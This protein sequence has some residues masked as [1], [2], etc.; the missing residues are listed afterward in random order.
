MRDRQEISREIAATETCNA[1][2]DNLAIHGGARFEMQECVT[3]HNPGSADANS[4][5]TVD[6]SVMTMP[7][8][9]QVLFFHAAPLPK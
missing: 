3:C 8:M 1:C 6:M 5:N 9:L 4:G 7:S 2:H